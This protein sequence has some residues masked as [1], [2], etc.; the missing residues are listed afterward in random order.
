MRHRIFWLVLALTAGVVLL[1]EGGGVAQPPPRKGPFGKKGPPGK[2]FRPALTVDQVVERLMAFDKNKDGKVT[3]DE[4]PERM[5]HLIALGDANKDG[6]LDKDEIRNLANGL[7]A[8]IGLATP[9]GPPGPGPGGL[10]SVDLRRALDDMRLTSTAK[11]KA[12][13]LLKAHDDK[14]RR[15]QELARAEL[16]MEMKE[17]LNEEDYKSFKAAARRRPGPPPKGAPRPQDLTRTLDE[18]QKDVEALRRKLQQ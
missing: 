13:Q 9:A 7:E 14:L 5:Q 10:A 3:A 1:G 17:I 16:V 4:L 18:L 6:A 15:L 8:F 2:G 12:A 11:D